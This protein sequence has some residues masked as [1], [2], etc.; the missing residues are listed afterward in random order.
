MKAWAAAVGG[1]P[2]FPAF[3][4]DA[5]RD[6]ARAIIEDRDPLVTGLQAY[7]ALEV[8]KS[9]YLS[10]VRRTPIPLPMS[11]A[12][13]AEADRISSGEDGLTDDAEG[14]GDGFATIQQDTLPS[15]ARSRRN[16]LL[17]RG[18]MPGAVC[19]RRMAP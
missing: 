2:G 13:R 9:V 11:A 15:T 3:H 18:R 19:P 10:Q 17:T 7:R 6:F 16:G 5:L 12:D 4:S 8:I 1:N 14:A